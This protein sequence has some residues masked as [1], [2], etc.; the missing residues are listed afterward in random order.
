MIKLGMYLI[1]AWLDSVNIRNAPH[2]YTKH[3]LTVVKLWMRM[4]DQLNMT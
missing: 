1:D 3:D 4:V 2:W